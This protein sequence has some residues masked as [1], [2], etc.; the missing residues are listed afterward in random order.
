MLLDIIYCDLCSTDSHAKHFSCL[1]DNYGIIHCTW[2]RHR[3]SYI[4][5]MLIF[6]SL[7]I[8]VNGILV[9]FGAISQ[10][11][12]EEKGQKGNVERLCC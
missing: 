2:P 3:Q 1:L 4:L 5:E 8:T 11:M 10:W 9:C 7:K 6:E 12:V